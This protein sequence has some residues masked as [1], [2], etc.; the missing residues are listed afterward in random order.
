[1]TQPSSSC[2]ARATARHPSVGNLQHGAA[3]RA[4]GLRAAPAP[5][6]CGRRVCTTWAAGGAQAATGVPIS[7][8]CAC[9]CHASERGCEV[10]SSCPSLPCR[11]ASHP[12]GRTPHVPGAAPA[13]QLQGHWRPR[14]P[15]LNCASPLTHNDLLTRPDQGLELISDGRKHR[16]ICAPRMHTGSGQSMSSFCVPCGYWRGGVVW[17]HL[18]RLCQMLGAAGH[19][20][21]QLLFDRHDIPDTWQVSFA[22]LL[23]RSH[24]GSQRALLHMGCVLLKAGQ[25]P[26]MG[27]VLLKAVLLKAAPRPRLACWRDRPWRPVNTVERGCC[28]A[29]HTN[30]PAPDNTAEQ[31]CCDAAYA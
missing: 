6:R 31:G 18:H 11:Q 28:D 1:M 13:A 25:S 23:T 5:E 8:V 21:S 29:A 7:A 15:V 27:C 10:A 26:H 3:V 22:S 2:G 20:R 30:T 12:G 19:F 17:R 24:A 16:R 4:A 14:G 9:I